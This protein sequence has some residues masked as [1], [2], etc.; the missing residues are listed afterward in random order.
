MD[1]QTVELLALGFQACFTLLQALVYVGLWARQRR[2]YFATWAAAWTLYA[3]RLGCIGLYLSTR[4][5]RW[6]F[7]HEAATWMSSLLLLFA[8]FQFSRG[9]PWRRRYLLFAAAS[10][11]WAAV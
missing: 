10:I 11:A 6:L 7:A 5:D 4:R 8:A 1:R 3:L 9:V 2:P